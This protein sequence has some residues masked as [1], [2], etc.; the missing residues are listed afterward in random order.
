MSQETN[1]Q[2]VIAEWRSMI[3]T[4]K[5]LIDKTPPV[6]DVLEPLTALQEKAQNSSILTGRQRQAIYDRCQNYLD[7]TYG[8][9][10][11]HAAA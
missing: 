9:N 11:S 5:S 3:D 6:K 4:F 8:K 7:G 1:E 2:L 10:L